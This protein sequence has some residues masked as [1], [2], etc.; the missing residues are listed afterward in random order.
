MDWLNWAH[1]PKARK[2]LRAYLRKQKGAIDRGSAALDMESKA[3]YISAGNLAKT[4]LFEQYCSRRNYKNADEL[5]IAIGNGE[6]N[7]AEV[8]SDIVVL[9]RYY[10]EKRRSAKKVNLKQFSLMIE[11]KDRRRL[12]DGIIHPL[13]VLGFD[14]SEYFFLDLPGSGRVV[15][16]IGVNVVG[17]RRGG[18]F[19]GQMQRAQIKE[20]V[21]RIGQKGDKINVLGKK[22][23]RALALLKAGSFVI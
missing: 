8:T 23:V 12:S 20:A 2:A 7:A 19:V 11:T 14:I 18:D 21:R 5:F 9:Y 17:G 22:Q 6:I 15:I 1:T 3:Y 10:L 4:K 13:S 16:V